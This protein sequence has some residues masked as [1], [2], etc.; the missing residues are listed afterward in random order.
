MHILPTDI[1]HLCV[2]VMI[3]YDC[4][5]HHGPAISVQFFQ[6]IVTKTD[7]SVLIGSV[8]TYLSHNRPL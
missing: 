2:I 7:F 6:L 4:T 5:K 8:C 3:S 1:L